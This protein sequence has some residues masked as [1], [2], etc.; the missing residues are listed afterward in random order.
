[1]VLALIAALIITTFTDA[2]AME[3][4]RNQFLDKQGYYIFPSPYSLPG[5]GSGFG[6]VGAMSNVANSYADFYVY[7]LQGDL[8]GGGLALS[9]VHLIPK[10]LVFDL[11]ASK[12]R[13]LF[14]QNF[15]ARGIGGDKDDYTL[16]ELDDNNFL[17]ARLTAIFSDR[18]LEVYIMGYDGSWHISA[19]HDSDGELIQSVDQSDHIDYGAAILGMRVDY[20][21]DYQNPRAGLRLDLNATRELER[22]SHSPDQYTMQ[23]SLTGY[24]PLRRWDTLVLHYYQADAMLI[25]EGETNRTAVEQIYGYDC[26]QGTPEQQTDCNNLVSTIISANRY[27]TAGGLGGTSRLRAYPMNRY[28]GA[29]VRFGGLEYRWNIT[30]ESTPFNIWIAKDI[31]TSI[32]MAF[33]FENLITASRSNSRC[34]KL[35]SV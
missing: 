9:D 32:Q 15:G 19:L 18:M 17:G 31:R 13:Q 28:N 11:T 16:L 5:I 30:E 24:I 7:A 22:E 34:P 2:G 35:I 1:M 14:I 4:R 25:S 26:T 21:D 3:R 27:G 6:L 23:Y 20:T 12:F 8:E 29:H 33:F 10:R